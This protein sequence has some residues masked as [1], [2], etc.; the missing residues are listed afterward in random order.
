MGKRELMTA[1]T[2]QLNPSAPPRLLQPELH[3]HLALH[4][5]RGGEMLVRLLALAR[6]PVELA[7]AQVAT[8]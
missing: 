6:A 8:P 7:E 3:A 4:R 5:R 2:V 1:L